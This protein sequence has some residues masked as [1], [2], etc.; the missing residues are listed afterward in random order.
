MPCTWPT[1]PPCPNPV[2][3][4]SGP[5]R[6]RS[7]CDEHRWLAT[8]RNERRFYARLL[9]KHGIDEREYHRDRKF[10]STHGLTRRQFGGV[11]I[12]GLAA[13]TSTSRTEG[14]EDIYKQYLEI[15]K[16]WLI[17]YPAA[18]AKDATEN[19]QQALHRYG[20]PFFQLL[21]TF[22]DELLAD[23]GGVFSEVEQ[24]AQQ[25]IDFYGEHDD[26]LRLVFAILRKTN[27]HRSQIAS[28]PYRSY[29]A[30]L[31]LAKGAFH[32]ARVHSR[33][34]DT[35]EAM[36]A[37]QQAAWWNHRLALHAG[38]PECAEDTLRLVQKL[39]G[40]IGTDAARW[41]SRRTELDHF[42]LL[43]KFGEAEESL[44]EASKHLGRL[45][46]Y[47]PLHLRLSLVRREVDFLLA[48]EQRS[49]AQDRLKEYLEDALL[50][51]NTYL[52]QIWQRWQRDFPHL[53]W[54]PDFTTS[55]VEG[56]LATFYLH[57]DL[58]QL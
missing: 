8:A 2:P 57:D 37:L 53:V 16:A 3:Q 25:A 6:P 33:K 7:Y 58:V 29:R 46:G 48:Q 49:R 40:E 26:Q 21:S 52:F 36:L 17:G 11:S 50:Y 31:G 23:I 13:L 51:P 41:E 20:S 44:Q 18:L 1:Y 43:G 47:S 54:S 22:C 12:P 35:R 14:E 5:G 9:R 27:L 39:A 45:P 34:H 55:Y 24:H 28:D 32:I 19:L 10:R 42:T 30:A 15:R 56:S 4:H 38:E